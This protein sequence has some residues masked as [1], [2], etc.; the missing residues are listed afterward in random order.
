[1]VRRV[2]PIALAIVCFGAGLAWLSA[3]G[4]RPSHRSG[5]PFAL[6]AAVPRVAR[7][8]E[9]TPA[10]LKVALPAAGDKLQAP[11]TPRPPPLTI[12]SEGAPALNEIALTFDDGPHPGFTEPLLRILAEH[13]IRAT[14]FLVGKMAELAG[15][16]VR[17]EAAAGHE[18]GNHTYSH[19]CLKTSTPELANNEL[20]RCNAVIESLTGEQ[21]RICRPPGGVFD[22]NAIAIVHQLDMMTVLWTCDPA[23]YEDIPG[24]EIVAR[25]LPA[26]SPGGI[27]LLH[28]GIQGTLDALPKI[29]AACDARGYKYVTCSEMAHH[30]VSGRAA[31]G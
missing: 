22:R 2:A 27:V 19:I 23:D 7:E 24:P 17:R 11:P 3:R 1:M 30:R 4:I 5:Q 13:K 15:D 31:D 8:Y 29:I 28:D 12:L 25:T 10:S 21:V 6:L 26:L 14:F 20:R 18:V 9:T 16:L